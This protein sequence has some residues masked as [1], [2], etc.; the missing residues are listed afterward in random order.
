MPI[1]TS[2]SRRPVDPALE[3]LAQALDR[4]ERVQRETSHV[5]TELTVINTVLKQ[6][7]PAHVQAG[8]IAQALQKND[9]M[10]DRLQKS[11]DELAEVNRVLEQELDERAQL[12]DELAS[13][14]KQL[15]EVGGRA[16]SS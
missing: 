14:R 1:D 9:E 8:D 16:S 2:S 5:A 3:P 4:N 15:A 12:E 7:I 11:A 10:E 6:E 13:T